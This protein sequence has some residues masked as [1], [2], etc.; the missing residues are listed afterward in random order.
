MEG[1]KGPTL[2]VEAAVGEL[3][4]HLRQPGRYPVARRQA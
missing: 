4:E 3:R 2:V 1:I